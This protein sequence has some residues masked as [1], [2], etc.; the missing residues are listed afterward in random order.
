[1]PFQMT[2]WSNSLRLFLPPL[3]VIFPPLSPGKWLSLKGL[4][5]V[6]RCI[7]RHYVDRVK[8]H[9]P[10]IRA[11]RAHC[12]VLD[13]TPLFHLKWIILVSF[14][15][16]ISNAKRWCLHVLIKLSYINTNKQSGQQTGRYKTSIWCLLVCFDMS[17]RQVWFHI[18][19]IAQTGN[20]FFFV[21]FFPQKL[22]LKI[23]GRFCCFDCW[24][25]VKK[26]STTN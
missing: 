25:L 10:P 4:F 15:V 22:H 7:F 14:V 3:S 5:D 1:M 24:Y 6:S 16:W 23:T 20:C 26:T 2:W 17:C 21:F 9:V 19:S 12:F 13:P 11:Q 18:P 8:L